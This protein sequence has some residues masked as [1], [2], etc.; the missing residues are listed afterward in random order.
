MEFQTA[1]VA[2]ALQLDHPVALPHRMALHQRQSAGLREQ[3]D[4]HH[5]FVIHLE[6][7]G[8]YEVAEGLMPDIGPGR[9]KREVVID[10]TRHAGSG[11]NLRGA[12]ASQQTDQS[13][14]R[15]PA[16]G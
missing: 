8:T 6:I 10:L 1:F 16:L 3:I 14:A 9:L 12:S 13:R 11:N 15:S 5:R 2:P 7:I 4:Q